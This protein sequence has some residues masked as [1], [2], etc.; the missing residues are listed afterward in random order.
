MRG[1]WPN[2]TMQNKVFDENNTV[3]QKQLKRFNKSRTM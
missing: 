3:K 2:N 1:K